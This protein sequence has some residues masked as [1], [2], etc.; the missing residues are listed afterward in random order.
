MNIDMEPTSNATFNTGEMI[1]QNENQLSEE[2]PQQKL[3]ENCTQLK[4][5]S[6]ECTFS[7]RFKIP[8]SF[9]IP[10]T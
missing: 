5:P 1:Q 8:S 2:L 6:H 9:Q 10:S 3:C 4:F 7:G